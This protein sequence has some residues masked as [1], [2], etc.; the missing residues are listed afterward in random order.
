MPA[1]HAAFLMK[2]VIKK[3]PE[4]TATHNDDDRRKALIFSMQKNIL[5]Q[6]AAQ[7][8]EENLQVLA[9]DDEWQ[10][11][12]Q[13]DFFE[14][15]LVILQVNARTDQAVEEVVG[16]VFTWMRN[17][18]RKLNKILNSPSGLLWN[19][20]KVVLFKSEEALGP[21]DS[22]GA[23][24]SDTD[25]A[26]RKCALMGPIHYIGPYSPVSFIAKIRPLLAD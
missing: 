10:L 17:Y 13:L 3:I 24:I 16:D 25:E 22:L 12:R 15:D 18:A 19:R 9:V 6:M 5:K 20:A 23:E 21:I 4:D 14:P 11:M 1:D 26:L 7:L 2:K 8:E